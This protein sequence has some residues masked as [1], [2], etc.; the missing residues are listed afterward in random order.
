[1][2]IKTEMIKPVKVKSDYENHEGKR[3]KNMNRAG[4]KAFYKKGKGSLWL[5]QT[6]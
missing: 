6:Y 3:I 1:M 5:L 2:H 4:S